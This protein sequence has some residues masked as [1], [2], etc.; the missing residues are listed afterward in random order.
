M[1]QT[2]PDPNQDHPVRNFLNNQPL[3]E[4]RDRFTAR[5]D[6]DINEDSRIFAN[7]SLRNDDGFDVDPL[8][9]FGLTSRAREQSLSINYVR[10]LSPQLVGSI[11]ASYQRD[12]WGRLSLQAG[13][14]GLLDSLGIAGVGTLDDLDEGY[15]DFDIAG[16]ASLGSGSSP[17]ASHENDYGLDLGASYVRNNHSIEAGVE[18]ELSQINNDRTG[19]LRRERS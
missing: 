4:N 14:R 3:I 16:Y 1:L 7:Y 19:G 2:I 18:I 9:I 13:Q 12:A 6:F 15:P 8:P 17:R 10:D 11:R 5:V